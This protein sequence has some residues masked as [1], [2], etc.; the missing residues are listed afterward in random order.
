MTLLKAL[1]VGFIA[2]I[3]VAVALSFT[4]VAAS[5]RGAITL[6]TLFIV[7]WLANANMPPLI[8]DSGWP[9]ILKYALAR[10]AGPILVNALG[11]P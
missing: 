3:L 4:D 8:R 2:S 7:T 11:L 9:S 5:S 10:S 6:A 1:A